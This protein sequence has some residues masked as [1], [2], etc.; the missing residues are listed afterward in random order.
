MKQKVKYIAIFAVL[1]ILIMVIAVVDYF[2]NFCG[3]AYCRIVERT[4]EE[5]LLQ[6]DYFDPT[7]YGT[8]KVYII[9]NQELINEF[10]KM[11]DMNDISEEDD[12]KVSFIFNKLWGIE[13]KEEGAYIKARKL[14]EIKDSD[15]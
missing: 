15:I 14:V 5:I 13:R 8:T 1:I 6:Q 7:E 9:V 2:N 4:S 12:L 3:I 11:L 10:D